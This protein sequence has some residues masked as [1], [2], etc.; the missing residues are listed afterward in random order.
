MK[1]IFTSL[2]FYTW[3]FT[4]VKNPTWLSVLRFLYLLMILIQK[5]IIFEKSTFKNSNSVFFRRIFSNSSKD[6]G[7][8]HDKHRQPSPATQNQQQQQQQQTSQEVRFWNLLKKLESIESCNF[9]LWSSCKLRILKMIFR[10][11][12]FWLLFFAK[13]VYWR[14]TFDKIGSLN[15]RNFL[16]YII[17]Y[18]RTYRY[19][20]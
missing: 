10:F 5:L 13:R 20:I 14:A 7:A 8:N 12:L 17:K 15:H 2:N 9:T 3:K 19:P 1:F 18:N 6:K 4:I 11:S 16:F